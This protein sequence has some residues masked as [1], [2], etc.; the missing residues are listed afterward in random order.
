MRLTQR[1][2]KLNYAAQQGFEAGQR[3]EFAVN[4]YKTGDPIF[5]LM[6]KQGFDRARKEVY[7]ERY[8]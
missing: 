7:S 5:A 1:E 8:L 4:P 6:W 3:S 2:I